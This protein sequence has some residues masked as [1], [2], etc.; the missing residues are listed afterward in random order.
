[1]RMNAFSS[2]KHTGIGECFGSGIPTDQDPWPVRDPSHLAQLPELATAKELLKAAA[3]HIERMPKDV[4]TLACYEIV[5]DLATLREWLAHLCGERRNLLL[6][7]YNGFAADA[8]RYAMQLA[9]QR[10]L[11]PANDSPQLLR[12]SRQQRSLDQLK[13]L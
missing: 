9:A 10:A 11:G 5:G 13:A 3:P 7:T 8:R 2:K 6:A 1:M 12:V 4:E